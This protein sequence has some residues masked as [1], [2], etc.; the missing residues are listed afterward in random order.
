MSGA[1]DRMDVCTV[2]EAARMLGV[3]E[4]CVRVLLARG[5]LSGWKHGPMWV[6]SRTSVQARIRARAADQTA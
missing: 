5:K 3:S 4:Q 6:V 1:G 2:R